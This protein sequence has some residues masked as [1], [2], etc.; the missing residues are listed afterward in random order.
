MPNTVTPMAIKPSVGGSSQTKETI[1]AYKG[2]GGPRIQIVVRRPS[3]KDAEVQTPALD[4]LELPIICCVRC[5][6]SGEWD[7]NIRRSPRFRNK[8]TQT[9]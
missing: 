9:D 2:S 1:T 5:G 6:N 7:L 4:P 8:H 3:K